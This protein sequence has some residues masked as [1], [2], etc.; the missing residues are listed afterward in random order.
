MDTQ[1]YDG[2]EHRY[3]DYPI[4][5]ILQMMGRA[6]RPLIDDNGKC[7]LLC[8]APKKLFYRKFLYEPFPVESHLDHFLSDHMCAEV[9]TKTIENKQ[10]AVDYLTWTFMYRRLTQNPNYYNLQG[11][12]HRHLSDHLSEL[13]ETT[14]AD[15]ETARC[16][17]IEE[18]MDV[19]PLNLGMIA[20][21]Y[22]IQYTTIELFSS[23]LQASTKLKGL[24][25]IL[26]SAAE[27]DTLPVRLREDDAL[28]GLARHM[29]QKIDGARYNDPHTKANVILQCHFSRRDVGREM[30]ADQAVVLDK[31]T[32][33]LQAMVDVIS[34]SGWLAPALAT[35]ELSQMS[36]QALWDRDSVLLQ[37][38]HVTREVAK[39]AEE[40]GVETI[41]D[42]MDME[43]DERVALLGMNEAQLADVAR[44]CNRYPNIDL[45]HEV[46]DEDEVASGDSVTVLV[47]LQ[48]EGDDE[49]VRVPKVHAPHFPKEKEEGWWLVIG[50]VAANS[51]LCIKR[52]SLQ[53]KAKVKLDFVAPEPGEYNLKLYLMSDSYLGCDQE[54][55][56]PLK[57]GEAVSEDEEEDEDE[58]EGDAE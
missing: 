13:V 6:C 46:E 44:V 51:L 25:E 2:A 33:L 54:Y 32:R 17:S 16:I 14:L 52:I 42:L 22:Y 43:D 34:S 38:P 5:D 15:L 30:Q 18:D 10:D 50:D 7:V 23:S 41:F 55:E 57:V 40:A 45:T 48:R 12:S 53:Q 49:A 39:R 29:P 56:L 27:F 8:H 4:T 3:T 36:V 24:L 11:A 26:A 35:M 1:F 37:L 47:Q 28:E 19:T 21:Y 31:A 20:S 9:V 58:E